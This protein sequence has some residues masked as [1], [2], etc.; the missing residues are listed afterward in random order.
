MDRHFLTGEELLRI[1]HKKLVRSFLTMLTQNEILICS[2]LT[3]TLFQIY[4]LQ[5]PCHKLEEKDLKEGS[6]FQNLLFQAVNKF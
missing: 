1:A 6:C 2:L 4:L 3:A 5:K